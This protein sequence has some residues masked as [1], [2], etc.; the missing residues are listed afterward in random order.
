MMNIV[1]IINPGNPTGQF[2]SLDE[3]KA[4]LDSTRAL[5]LIVLDESFIDFAGDPVPSLLSEASG[6]PNLLIVRS[7]SKHCGVPGLR[8]GYAYSENKMLLDKLRAVVPLWNV[9]SIAEYFLSMLPRTVNEYHTA[10][11]RVIG[12]MIWLSEQLQNL[13]GLK[14]YKSGANFVLLKILGDMSSSTLQDTLLRKHR[15]YVRDCTNKV[16]MDNKHIRVASQGPEKDQR[17]VKALRTIL[18]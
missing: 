10:R 6:Y 17:L 8:L 14:T 18:G 2:H 15:M 13:S 5:D 12:D 11:M 4:F 9:N 1:A 3:M 16:G 7:M